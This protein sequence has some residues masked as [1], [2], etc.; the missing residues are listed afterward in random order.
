MT[1]LYGWG[2]KSERVEDYVPDVRFERTSIIS[3]IGLKGH[4]APMTFKGT[5]NGELF[6]E[7]VV[8]IL[9][10]VLE[11]GDIL[12]MDNLSSHKVLKALKPLEDKGIKILWLPQYSPDFNPIE[13]SW[14]KVKSILRKK[15]PRTYEE[16]EEYLTEALESITDEDCKN[17]F[18]H[19]GYFFE[20]A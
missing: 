10:P 4:M 19:D 9:V 5:L 8:H 13:L 15:K 2:L 1:R 20:P 12:I 6:G 7:Y 18:K 11:K 17:W 16:L 14:S 3:V